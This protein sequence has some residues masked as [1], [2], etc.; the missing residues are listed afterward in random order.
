MFDRLLI[1]LDDPWHLLLFLW[2]IGMG[3]VGLFCVIC[4][5]GSRDE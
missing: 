5:G 1:I 2:L 4:K 3:F